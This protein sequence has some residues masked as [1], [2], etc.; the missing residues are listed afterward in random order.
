MY[1]TE[2]L[3]KA[4]VLVVGSGLF[5]SVMAERIASQLGK[6]VVVIDKRN[7]IGGNC[8]TENDPDTGV[9]VHKYGTHIFHTSDELTWNYINQFT[10]FNTYQHR[11]L[12]T[13]QNKVY[14][15]PIN[16]ST[17]NSYYRQNLS[18][19]ETKEFIL[20]EIRRDSITHPTNLEDKAI[21]LIGKPLY[22]AFIKGYS[23][24]QWQKNLKTI[25]ASVITR[26][27]VRFN[28]N[29]RYFNDTYEG[30][31]IDGYTP[32][33]EKM[34]KSPNINVFLDTDYF[35][36]KSILKKDLLT[37]YTGPIDRFFDYKYGK[38]NWRTLDLISKSLEIDDFQGTSVM[39]Y[40]DSSVPYT[41]IHEFK[42]L[43]PEKKHTSGTTIMYEYSKS[44]NEN[45]DPYY[46]VNTEIDQNIY[47]LY[48]SEANSMQNIIFGGRLA[49]YQYLDM[50]QVIGSA[51]QVFDRKVKRY[52]LKF[53]YLSERLNNV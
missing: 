43:H 10:K 48:K 14:S 13:S 19:S 51:L 28:Y 31:P 23:E 11:V 21:S 24:K 27:P 46:P 53:N 50:H 49:R 41:R 18:P 47:S 37:I 33:F 22:E 20:S 30:I 52:F 17:I 16:L 39:N 29:D 44:A 25:P 15:M 12:T 40:A 45:E 8:Y 38:L 9:N 42:H 32:I 4:D 26:L 6:Q 1:L 3:S 7:H 5:G 34:L 36:I 2:A 35:E